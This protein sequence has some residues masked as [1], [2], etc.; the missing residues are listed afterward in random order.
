MHVL[1]AFLSGGIKI[2]LKQKKI[3]F[4]LVIIPSST[5]QLSSLDVSINKPTKELIRKEFEK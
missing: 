1:D 2:K 5:G 4:D 3:N